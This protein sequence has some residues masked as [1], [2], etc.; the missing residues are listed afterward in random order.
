MVLAHDS[1]TH[2][3]MSFFLILISSKSLALLYDN[4]D[5]EVALSQIDWQSEIN[6]IMNTQYFAQWIGVAHKILIKQIET[7]THREYTE[8]RLKGLRHSSD[9]SQQLS[10]HN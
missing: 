9:A 10:F 7:L 2:V 3:E 5:Y 4:F 8:T 6:K 1:F